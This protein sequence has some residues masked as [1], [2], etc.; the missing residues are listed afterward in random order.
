MRRRI[1]WTFHNGGG[2]Y[3][4][5]WDSEAG[6]VNRTA[7]GW[8]AYLEL[9]DQDERKIGKCYKTAASAKAAVVR[10]Y[11]KYEPFKP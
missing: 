4:E 1:Q 2:Q 9:P 10:A 11:R 6:E 7:S 5:W 8:D 3:P